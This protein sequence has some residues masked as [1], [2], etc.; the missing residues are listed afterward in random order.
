MGDARITPSPRHAIMRSSCQRGYLE[1]M[2]EPFQC[3]SELGKEIK[4]LQYEPVPMTSLYRPSR[5]AFWAI[6]STKPGA[7]SFSH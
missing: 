1:P 3:F 2:K 7:I 4:G 5:I 6:R